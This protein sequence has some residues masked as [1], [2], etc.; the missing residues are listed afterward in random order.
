M[1]RFWWIVVLSG[2]G[3]FLLRWLPLQLQAHL[4]DRPPRPATPLSRVL[5]AMLAT[6]GAAAITALVVAS[7]AGLPAPAWISLLGFGAILG[8]KK[9][10]GGVIGPTFAGVLCFGV[11]LALR[12]G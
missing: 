9:W 5:H 2:L 11:L 7:G 8:V 12:A 1:S 6:L 3:T 10:R 4:H